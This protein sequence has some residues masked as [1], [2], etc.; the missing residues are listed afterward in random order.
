[1]GELGVCLGR[2]DL[3]RRQ[4]LISAQQARGEGGRD[5]GQVLGAWAT[6]RKSRAEPM[7]S[8]IWAGL[9]GSSGTMSVLS[10]GHVVESM[11]Q[12]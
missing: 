12:R 8:S 6:L 4:E 7:A 3:S 2:G 9:R 11:K 10:E 1:M 5:L